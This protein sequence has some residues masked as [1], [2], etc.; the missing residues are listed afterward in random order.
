MSNPRFN[1]RQEIERNQ[2]EKLRALLAALIPENRFYSG[3]FRSA[4]IRPHISSLQSFQLAMPFTSKQELVEDQRLHPPYGSNLTYPLE[5][6]KRLSQTSAT[7][8]LPLRWLDTQQSWDWMLDCWRQVLEAGSV[9]PEDRLFF[10]FS[11]AP[12]LGFWTAFESAIRLGCLCIPGGGLSSAARLG[13]IRDN[14]VTLLFCTPTYALRLAEVASEEQVDLAETSV[15]MIFVAGEP[16]GSLPGVRARIE[17]L[18]TGARVIDHHGMTEIGPVSYQ[19]SKIR[20][21]LHILESDYIP[22]V[23]DPQDGRPVAPGQTGELVLSN[24]GRTG[25][26]LLRYRTGDLVSPGPRQACECGSRELALQGGILARTD[27]MVIVRGVNLYPS[28]VDEI[29][30]AC[31]GAGEYR[32]E[33]DTRRSLPELHI[34][35]EPRSDLND[36]ESLSE[37]L[38]KAL[39]TALAL[40]IPVS[41]VPPG[42]LPRFE[43]KARRWVRL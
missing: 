27:E 38:Q 7:S 15:R 33:I 31:E 3:R 34:Q 42:S 26:P 37:R 18:W 43:M 9:R 23:V 22:E 25:S 36:S 20:D 40:R 30:R 17:T 6:Y 13:M 19:C 2:L 5:Q 1:T 10:A 11:F 24:L 8:G 14:G 32:V 12:F 21:R 41:I 28:A 39:N 35:V 4:R 16:G 29:V